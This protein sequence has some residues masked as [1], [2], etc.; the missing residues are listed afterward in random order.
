MRGNVHFMVTQLQVASPNY[1]E[2]TTVYQW[3]T[4]TAIRRFCKTCG[5]LPWYVPRSNP[6]GFGVTLGCVDFGSNGPEIEHK[7]YDG[8]NWEKSYQDSKISQETAT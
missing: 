5:I 1:N 4:K 3:G 7:T 8:V 6:D 2:E